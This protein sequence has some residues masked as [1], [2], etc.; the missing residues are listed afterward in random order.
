MNVLNGHNETGGGLH[1]VEAGS[2]VPRR[3]LGRYL[4]QARE[5][6]GVSLEAAARDLEWSRAKM[7]RVE[8]GQSPLRRHD[9]MA[10]C[11]LY[12]ISA[13]HAEALVALATETKAKGWWH[14]Y[15]QAVPAWFDLY[16]GLE[17]AAARL[18]HYESG[19]IPGLL[20]IPEY[21][22][23]VF[24]TKPGASEAEVQQKV[25]VRMERKK[26]LERRLPPAP[27]FDVIIDEAVLRR[28]IPDRPAMQQQLAYLVNLAAREPHISV[29]VLPSAIGPHV[30]STA[31]DFVILDF[32]AEGPR[33]AEPTTIYSQNLTGALYLDK[34][35]EVDAY[36]RVWTGLCE[37]S[38]DERATEQ[39]VA[40]IIKGEWR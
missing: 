31:G 4:R 28:P 17:A 10:M 13:E 29:R 35:D 11:T 9:V 24:R 39:L 7:Y 15:G 1:V 30:A 34:P 36:E 21:A 40:E 22:A 16:L 12:R 2:S 32:P 23:A 20:Q 6:A 8:G 19:V 26:L 25:A 18:R 14:S 27:S 5:A 38:L 33:Q 3:S 37:L